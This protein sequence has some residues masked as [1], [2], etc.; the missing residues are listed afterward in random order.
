MN[1]LAVARASQKP[2]YVET[3]VFTSIRGRPT[4][5]AGNFIHFNISGSRRRGR[6]KEKK[7][8]RVRGFL[9]KKALGT[10]RFVQE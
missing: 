6:E 7:E 9:R 2:A 1:A 5:G 3:S 8:Y 4:Y 10:P